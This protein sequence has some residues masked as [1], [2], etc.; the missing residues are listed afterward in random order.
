MV[1]AVLS[2][3][4]NNQWN[5][6]TI[7][8]L[9]RKLPARPIAVPPL[10]IHVR[11]FCGME[12]IEIWL[13]LRRRAFARQ[14]LGIRDWDAADFEREFLCK[15]WWHPEA[16]L[17]A[18]VKP[19]IAAPDWAR[20]LQVVGTVTLARRGDAPDAKPV[21]HWL[22]VSPPRAA[23]EL[24]G[25]WSPRS[26]RPCGI[27]AA[28]RF[29]S[30]RTPNGWRPCGCTSRSA[31]ARTTSELFRIGG[32]FAAGLVET[33]TSISDPNVAPFDQH[34]AA[35]QKSQGFGIGL[36]FG[37]KHARS[38][39]LGRVVVQHRHDL[40]QKDRTVVVLVV[41]KVHGA[42]ADFTRRIPIPLRGRDDHKTRVRR[43]PE[44]VPDGY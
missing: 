15:P 36:A 29:G 6:P 14:R 12:D 39:D 31:T 16:M 34:F 26:K 2:D 19:G 23:A 24:A 8:R 7:L 37:L 9:T 4:G 42:P 5:M 11:H 3:R 1:L 40:L 25:C 43:T 21:V 17:F 33:P 20:H 30:K 41:D 13:D 28:G 18:E 35:D 27:L 38:Q 44:S 22:A 32:R 10:G